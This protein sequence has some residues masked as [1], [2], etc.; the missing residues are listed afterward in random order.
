M[1]GGTRNPSPACDLA[2]DSRRR[3]RFAV[4]IKGNRAGVMYDRLL[5]F[6]LVERGF[7]FL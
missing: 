7:G 1:D 6:A 5:H 4:R 3:S 2:C